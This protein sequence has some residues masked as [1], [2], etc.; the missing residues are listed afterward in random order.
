MLPLT[1]FIILLNFFKGMMAFTT[2]F[3]VTG[4]LTPDSIGALSR[5]NLFIHLGNEGEHLFIPAGTK[6]YLTFQ[7]GTIILPNDIK[8]NISFSLSETICTN[9]NNIVTI[10]AR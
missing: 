1:L 8:C 10:I 4:L 2:D 5:L 3:N 9:S 7:M 6:I